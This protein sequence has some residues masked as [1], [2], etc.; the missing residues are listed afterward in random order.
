MAQEEGMLF[1]LRRAKV[2]E[3]E[4]TEEHMQQFAARLPGEYAAAREIVMTMGGLPLALDQAGAYIEETGCSLAGYLRRYQQQRRHL[5]ARRGMMRGDH[6]LSVVATLGLACQQVAQQHPAALELLR[7][8][9]FLYPDAIPEELL[10]RGAPYLGPVL[11]P[12]VADISQFDGALALLRAFSLVQRQPETQTLSLHRLVQVILQ[13][14]MNAQEQAKFRRRA[15]HLLNGVFPEITARTLIETWQMCERLLPQAMTFVTTIPDHCQG[16][17]LAA[18]FLK[19][20]DYLCRR[21]QYEQAEPLYQRAL[22]LFEQQVGSDHPQVGLSLSKLASLYREQGKH[23]QAKPLFRQ[24]LCLL[25]QALGPEHPEVAFALNGLAMVYRR[26]GYYEQAVL[27]CQ[28]ALRIREL[29]LGPEHPD[30]AETLIGLGLLYHEQGHY[31]QAEPLYRRALHIWEQALGP[32]HPTIARPLNN[33]GVLYQEQGKYEQAEPLCQRAV[34]LSE[35][36]WGPEHPNVGVYLDSLATLYGEMGKY[37]Q[38]ELV[39]QCALRIFEQALGPEHCLVAFSLHGLALLCQKRGADEEAE[40]LYRRALQIREQHQGLHYPE[41][42]FMLY[43][44]ALLRQRQGKLDEALT[45]AERA[46]QILSPSV[47]DTH[48]KMVATRMLCAQLVEA[49]GTTQ[50]GVSCPR[51]AKEHPN[52]GRTERARGEA[53]ISPQ[54]AIDCPPLENDPLQ[55]FLDACCELHPRAWCRS[56]DLWQAYEDWVKERQELYPLSRRA[57]IAQLKEHGC[58]ADRTM[59]ARIWRGIAMVKK[60]A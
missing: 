17:E 6:P 12:L 38:A 49:R 58:R 13:E 26:Q 59:T 20:A 29:A 9:A 60:E 28:L 43:D 47:G 14:G 16:Q 32:E 36:A 8:C 57:L 31:E 52:Q 39:H 4:A 42:G 10:L 50:A 5:L 18:V 35:Q 46:L 55:E 30:V 37:E 40:T 53:F 7:F 2:L 27:L 1:V 51:D 45:L 3:P 33:L 44:L 15:V 41:M 48:P 19:A 34:R 25:E 24:A 22:H 23:E 56:A 11:G 21:F 54:K